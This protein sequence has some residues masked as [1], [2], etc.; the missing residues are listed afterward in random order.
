MSAF[1]IEG[2]TTSHG[3]RVLNCSPEHKVDEKYVARLG[4]MV[5]CPK[6][7]DVYPIVQVMPRGMSMGGKPTAFQGDKT[8]CGATLIASQRWPP[9]SRRVDRPVVDPAANH[10][11]VADDAGPYRGRFQV[12]DET[13]GRPIPNHL[14]SL[15]TAMARRS[16]AQQ[17]RTATLNGTKLMPPPPFSSLR[18]LP[19]M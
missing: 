17:T 9:R 1:I 2:D 16:R 11:S 19:R 5:S 13:T 7:G 6:C 14:Y 3:G 10:Q 18:I 12:L 8:A 15:Q 4:D